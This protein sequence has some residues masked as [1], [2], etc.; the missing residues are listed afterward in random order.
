MVQ[1]NTHIRRR[2]LPLL[3]MLA[4]SVVLALLPPTQLIGYE[5]GCVA[6]LV[7]VLL[8]PILTVR[9]PRYQLALWLLPAGVLSLNT[10]IVRHCNLQKGLLWYVLLVVPCALLA[11]TLWQRVGSRRFYLVIALSLGADLY[12][13]WRGPSIRVFDPLLGYYAGSLYD[14]SLPIPK[15]LFAQVALAITLVV[16]LQPMRRVWPRVAASVAAAGLFF[17]RGELGWSVGPK[18]LHQTLS[19][20]LVTEHLVIHFPPNGRLHQERDL[21]WPEAQRIAERLTSVMNVHP[22]RPTH[23]YF[24]ENPEDKERLLGARDTYFTRPWKPEIHITYTGPDLSVLDHELVHA[25]AKEWSTS[26]LGIPTRYLIV[27]NMALVEGTAVAL[28]QPYGPPPLSAMA[29]AKRSH[30]APDINTLFSP[31]G[32]YSEQAERAYTAAGAFVSHV[33]DQA[34]IETLRQAYAGD[35]SLLLPHLAS[36]NERIGQLQV[37]D[38]LMRSYADSMRGRALYQRICGREQ[39]LRRDEGERALRRGERALAADCFLKI[40]ADDP[41]DTPARLALLDVQLQEHPSAPGPQTELAQLDPSKMSLAEELR[42][43]EMRLQYGPSEQTSSI[44]KRGADIAVRKDE[45]R[46]WMVRLLLQQS[47]PSLLLALQPGTSSEQAVNLLQKAYAR[48]PNRALAGYLLARRLAASDIKTA[49][50]LADEVA[51]H[52][53]ELLAFEAARMACEWSYL[54]RNKQGML[55]WV[56]RLSRVEIQDEEQKSILGLWQARAKFYE[57]H[58]VW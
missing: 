26:W 7:A 51:D 52:V 12:G 1:T 2:L 11:R 6:T 19:E 20:I 50:Q 36:F 16:A 48:G 10:L 43:L 56:A 23:V 22:E 8:T 5:A 32:F 9:S 21:V 28:A 57:A 24:Y 27:P 35:P 53:P 17:A 4:V 58:P 3:L 13:V 33:V 54:S 47:D 25:F 42:W 38:E 29:A 46:K 41:N 45:R 37:S 30:R 18:Q 49:L 31:L 14:E 44:I 39:A 15:P 40:L 55:A 34:G